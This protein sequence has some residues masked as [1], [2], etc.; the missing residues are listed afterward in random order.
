VGG[1]RRGG[2]PPRPPPKLGLGF[3]F[4]FAEEI[5]KRDKDTGAPDRT[6]R[7]SDFRP[8]RRREG[9]QEEGTLTLQINSS[10]LTLERRCLREKEVSLVFPNPPLLEEKKKKRYS[11]ERKTSWFWPLKW[12]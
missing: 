7:R 5:R 4:S 3:D 6:E 2:A 12:Y 11:R 8:Q 9:M 10:P 1:T